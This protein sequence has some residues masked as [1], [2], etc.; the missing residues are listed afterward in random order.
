M[1]VWRTSTQS[2]SL[3]ACGRVVFTVV[4]KHLLA[5]SSALIID[6]W[7]LCVRGQ[8]DSPVPRF[9]GHATE[10]GHALPCELTLMKHLGS[11]MKSGM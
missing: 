7:S 2:I 6:G 3:S 10:Y 8:S 4:Q 11:L 5:Q 9:E 1:I